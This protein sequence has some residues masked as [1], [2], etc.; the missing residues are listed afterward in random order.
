M[1][2]ILDSN[3]YVSDYRMEGVNFRSLF[4][5]L[6]K[7][8]SNLVLF[9][10]VREEV[11]AEF[12]R[13]LEEQAAK[14][15]TTWEAYRRLHFPKKLS[16]FRKPDVKAQQKELR[17][18]LM[19]PPASVK[20]RYQKD[21]SKILVYE[22]FRRGIH[23][24]PPADKHGEQLRDVI[25]WLTTLDYTKTF[26]REVAFISNDNGFWRD[27]EVHPQIAKDI[28]KLGAKLRVYRT[29]RSFVEEN[30]PP[31][32]P[33][34]AKW[35]ESIFTAFRPEVIAAAVKAF[36]PRMLGTS[37]SIKSDA[38][39]ESVQFREG[40]IFDVAPDVQVVDL[41]FSVEVVL[42]TRSITDVFPLTLLTNPM[43]I[44]AF[45]ARSGLYDQHVGGFLDGL[46]GTSAIFGSNVPES[47]AQTPE[48]MVTENRWA[49]W[50]TAYASARLIKGHVSEK[51][52]SDF[53][54]VKIE[55]LPVTR[56]EEIVEDESKSAE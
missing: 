12:A 10:I 4:D 22:V 48:Q 3:V 38:S 54:I 44:S 24:I 28:D 2:I 6:K 42:Q 40:K 49:I 17:A 46:R 27:K 53:K 52:I 47:P 51:E 11:I 35:A 5:Y 8:Q 32:K 1:D 13:D 15:E 29:I 25:I 14:T 26:N 33:A 36:Q 18:R 41:L 23:R 19:K 56:A 21:T 9:R 50:G 31:A 55:E 20:L 37:M 39:L 34:E 7:T 16:P 45:P 43:N 30:S